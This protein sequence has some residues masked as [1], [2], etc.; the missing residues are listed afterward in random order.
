MPWALSAR[1][2][3]A[4]RAQLGTLDQIRPEPLGLGALDVGH[5]LVATRAAHEHRA[6]IV[7]ADRAELLR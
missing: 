7:G 4:L 6:V 1:S 2:A 5:S 3:E